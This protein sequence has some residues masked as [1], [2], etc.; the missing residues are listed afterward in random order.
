M[1]SVWEALLMI[2]ETPL[3]KRLAFKETDTHWLTMWA[4]WRN[5]VHHQ[6]I[7][8]IV[9]RD[10]RKTIVKAA[11][12]DSNESTKHWKRLLD[13]YIPERTSSTNI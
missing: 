4:D 12:D 13:L 9:R 5:P 1:P 7:I 11:Y 3:L 2:E 8:E 10:D 6:T